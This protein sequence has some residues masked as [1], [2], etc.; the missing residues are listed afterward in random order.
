MSSQIHQN[1]FPEVEAAVTTWSSCMCQ[2]PAPTSLGF[3]F[4]HG[5]VAPKGLGHY[6]CELAKKSEGTEYL[7]KRQH[8]HDGLILF[9]EVLKPSQDDWGRTQGTMGAAMALETNLNQA[10]LDLLALGS[11][12]KDSAL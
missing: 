1:Y 9:Q 7:L 6:F 4:H 3:C 11:T 5:H 12:R 10:L 2:P 8:Q